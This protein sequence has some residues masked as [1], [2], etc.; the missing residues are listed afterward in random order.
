MAIRKYWPLKCTFTDIIRINDFGNTEGKS[1][2]GTKYILRASD[3]VS[4][5]MNFA[6]NKLFQ[7][8]V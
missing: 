4:T 7:K 8:C 5:Y 1:A 2:I 3:V 6:F